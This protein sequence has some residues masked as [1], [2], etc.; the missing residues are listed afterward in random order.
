MVGENVAF[1]SLPKGAVWVDFTGVL[2]CQD[3]NKIL[4]PLKLA[5]VSCR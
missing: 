2:L 4:T 3:E 5:N 1:E